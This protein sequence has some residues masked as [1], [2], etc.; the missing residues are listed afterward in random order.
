MQ[1]Q[2]HERRK[3]K[4]SHNYLKRGTRICGIEQRGHDGFS[5]TANRE[6]AD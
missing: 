3:K 6:T 5:I 2:K 4:A 1:R